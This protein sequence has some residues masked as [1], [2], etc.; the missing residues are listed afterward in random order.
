M[1][2]GQDRLA[3]K[4]LLIVDDDSATAMAYRELFAV[5]RPRMVV[6]VTLTAEAALRCVRHGPYDV[7]LSD[8]QMP[9]LDGM[10]L[11]IACH[12]FHPGTPFILLTAHGDRTLEEKATALG[13]YA[14][15]H[16]P[17]E[18]DV[19]VQAVERACTRFVRPSDEATSR[20]ADTPLS[21]G[22]QHLSLR[23]REI[24]KQL[25][26]IIAKWHDKS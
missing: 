17:V 13:A 4:R 26:S 6:D 22:Q 20:N 1:P 10:G 25:Q 19:L 12:L 16:K 18:N 7:I 11:L 5:S 15:F 3:G 8:Q 9:G 21:R 14:L 23:L 2:K 24:D